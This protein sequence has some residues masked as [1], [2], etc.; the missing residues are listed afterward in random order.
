M[1]T[2][3]NIGFVHG[4][5]P[6]NGVADNLLYVF[7]LIRG[8]GFVTGLEIEDLS[9]SSR[10]GTSAAED[11][12]SVEPTDENDFVGIGNIERLA[13]HFLI[14]KQKS[15]LDALG[16]G[17][18]RLDRPDTLAGIVT[19]LEIAGR[20]HQPFENFGVMSRMENDKPHTA[21]NRLL[22]TV[23]D[24]VTDSRVTHMSPP[25]KNVRIRKNLLAKTV[26]GHI[27]C[28]RTNLDIV[29]FDHIFQITVD[30]TGI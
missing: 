12:T 14:L 22:Y 18:I 23:H 30:A 5:S 9:I 29:A 1:D 17:M 16:N 11:L 7:I 15:V 25:D 26:L 24:L 20:T 6:S 13:V 3:N 28:C 10:K 21:E 27:E 4:T 8:I 2:G 19:P